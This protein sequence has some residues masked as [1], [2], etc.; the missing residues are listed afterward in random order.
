MTKGTTATCKPGVAGVSICRG[1]ELA[2]ES[3]E[4]ETSSAVFATVRASF[5]GRSDVSVDRSVNNAY[6][7]TSGART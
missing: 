5:S 7:V 4:I 6:S 3:C 1:D 2:G